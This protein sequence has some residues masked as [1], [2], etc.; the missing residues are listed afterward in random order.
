MGGLLF[1]DSWLLVVETPR[2]IRTAIGKQTQPM[3]EIIDQP[4]AVGPVRFLTPAVWANGIGRFLTLVR[5]HSAVLMIA[6]W[7][8]P[9]GHLS[10]SSDHVVH[11]QQND[12]AHH[13]DQQAVEIQTGDAHLTEAVE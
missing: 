1:C 9:R 2:A 7:C 13:G 5:R 4:G 8:G 11:D 6:R 12:R 10:R 3:Q